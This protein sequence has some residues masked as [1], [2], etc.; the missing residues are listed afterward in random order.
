MKLRAALLRIRK[1][2][3]YLICGICACIM[4]A[5]VLSIC[6]DVYRLIGLWATVSAVAAGV[7]SCYIVVAETAP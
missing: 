4:A 7:L 2:L 5:A 6:I 3:F 1:A